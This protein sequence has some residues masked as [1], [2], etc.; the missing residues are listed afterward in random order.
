MLPLQGRPDHL[1]T[2]EHS[3]RGCGETD[4]AAD[5]GHR[6]EAKSSDPIGT[7]IVD[8]RAL[9]ARHGFSRKA[10]RPLPSVRRKAK[11]T[12]A[13][14]RIKIWTTSNPD[15]WLHGGPVTTLKAHERCE[16][17]RDDCHGQDMGFMELVA[18]SQGGYASEKRPF[19]QR[20]E[21][22]QGP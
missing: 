15:R 22:V 11:H 6:T 13:A 12:A 4:S 19:R 9:S 2:S 18:S 3:H 20:S 14:R 5:T 21:S 16:G 1:T 7:R 10:T 17:R 8:R